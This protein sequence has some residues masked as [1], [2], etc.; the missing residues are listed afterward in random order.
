MEFWIARGSPINNAIL[1]E[2]ALSRLMSS[3]YDNTK[4]ASTVE[5]LKNH[6]DLQ[7]SPEIA[8]K[9]G[10]IETSLDATG[11]EENSKTKENANCTLEGLGFTSEQEYVQS[12]IDPDKNKQ[13]INERLHTSNVKFESLA[14]FPVESN[15]MLVLASE[16]SWEEAYIAALG[17]FE[18]SNKTDILNIALEIF[19]FEGA[20]EHY[21]DQLIEAGGYFSPETAHHIVRQ[22]KPELLEILDKHN[23]DFTYVKNG[24]SLELLAK[25]HDLE[26]SE[27]YASLVAQS[28]V[29][30][31]PR[32]LTPDDY[33]FLGKLHSIN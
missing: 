24:I 29:E 18:L 3:E 19:L 14:Q 26:L 21:I 33:A 1:I 31:D 9:L 25:Y 16:K 10:L 11:M 8:L 15:K 6:I 4:I 2:D 22:K 20:P 28:K 7:N 12:F 23:F 27:E 13:Y 5:L 32:G 17:V 30:Y